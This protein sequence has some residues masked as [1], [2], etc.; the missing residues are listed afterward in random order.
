MP[1]P[2]RRRIGQV[3]IGSFTGHSVPVELTA[4]AREFD[5]GGVTLFARNVGSPEQVLEAAIAIESLGTAAPAW[6]S[7]DQEG[8]RVARLKTP[9]TVWPPASTLGRAAGPDLAER[10]ARALARELRAVGITLDFAPVLDVLTNQRQPR[11]RRPGAVRRRRPRRRARRRDHPGDAGRRRGGLRQALPGTRRHH[12]RL[13]LRTAARRTWAGAAARGIE[14]VPFRAAIAAEVACVMTAHVL[15]PALDEALPAT[16]SPGILGLLRDELGHPGLIVSDDLEMQAISRRWTPA[17]AAVAAIGAGCD[18][19]LVCAGDLDVQ[20]AGA[21][22]AGEGGRDGGDS[23]GPARRRRGPRGPAKGAFPRRRTA[24]QPAS[25][26]GPAGRSSGV[27]STRWWRRKWRPSHDRRRDSHPRRAPAPSPPA[28]GDRIALVAPASPVQPDEL[29]RG[30]DEL[31]PLG[32]EPVYDE[33]VLARHGYVAGTPALRAASLADA[34]RDPS[35]RGLVAVRGGYGSQQMLPPAR[36]AMDCRRS[37]GVRRLQ[38]HHGA[39]RL[40]RRARWGG[41]SRADG[42]RAP[43]ARHRRL[44]SGVVPGCGYPAGGDGHAGAARPRGVPRRARRAGRCSAA[45]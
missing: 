36:S 3:L 37:E 44:R 10:F 22:G 32:F 18:T 25:A 33:R 30:A 6:V 29:A 41:V 35:V 26:C 16:L 17:E 27:K 20:A 7:V 4:L 15:V 28:P 19:V 31:R 38:R 40:A 1:M 45:R 34:W 21:R 23:A 12:R 8:G 42:R 39:A 2:L 5:L 14:F 9:F 24:T 13:A 43:R 11:H